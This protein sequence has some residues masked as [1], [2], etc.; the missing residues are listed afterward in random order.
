L[1]II[2]EK[3]KLY[4]EAL[5]IVEEA[6]QLGLKDNTVTGYQGRRLKILE[7]MRKES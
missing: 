2:L 6:I 4:K 3:K 1:A 5:L 7:K